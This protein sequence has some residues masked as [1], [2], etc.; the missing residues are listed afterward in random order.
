MYPLDG[1][2][3]A[4]LRMGSHTR[5]WVLIAL[6]GLFVASRVV[7]SEQASPIPP[8]TVGGTVTV[9][10]LRNQGDA[11]QTVDPEKVIRDIFKSKYPA[12]GEEK[13]AEVSKQIVSIAESLK[14]DPYLIFAVADV[15]YES[16]TPAVDR[17]W[18][19]DIKV[20]REGESPGGVVVPSVWDDI[21]QVAQSLK[22]DLNEFQ[23][24]GLEQALK[25]YYFG[26]SRMRIFQPLSVSENLLVQKALQRLR[27]VVAL[28]SGEPQTVRGTA[29]TGP[30][31]LLLALVEADREADDIATRQLR[32]DRYTRI[33]TAYSRLIR[34]FNRKIKEDM[35]ND[36]AERIIYYS[37]IYGI[38]SRLFFAVLA[39][40]SR[41]EP[42]AVS[43]KGA[44][45]LGQLMPETARNLGVA[46]PFDPDQNLKG[47]AS[48]L[49]DL[50][51]RNSVE[52]AL[53]AY[54]AGEERVR[55][56]GGIPPIRETR[57]YVRKVLT[58]YRQI[59][60]TIAA[61]P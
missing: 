38:D 31:T 18:K 22:D 30:G 27:E 51:S 2:L 36:I 54:N 60:G 57:L 47:S 43:P 32:L 52:N 25:A 48:Y 50:L 21:V 37:A 11:Q 17:R 14:M 55:E 40:E 28:S 19:Y 33:K 20:I 41:F 6:F 4:F 56:A 5:G 46:D 42:R 26:S 61:T 16:G 45:G 39:V 3:A 8:P 9:T 10:P 49:A 1:R 13:A 53:A 24:D 44:M 12:L 58:I 29:G 7:G 23:K 15:E 34:F 59:G 35:A